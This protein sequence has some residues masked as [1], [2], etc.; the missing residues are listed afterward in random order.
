MLIVLIEPYTKEQVD[1][2]LRVN[3]I[4]LDNKIMYDYVLLLLCVKLI[5]LEVL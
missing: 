5:I 3:D 4:A 2:L 1:E